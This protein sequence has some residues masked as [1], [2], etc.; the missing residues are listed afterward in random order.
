MSWLSLAAN[1]FEV[2]NI[3]QRNLKDNQELRTKTI[4]SMLGR[5]ALLS[6]DEFYIGREIKIAETILN[7]Y[8]EETRPPHQYV[9]SD[10][11]DLAIIASLGGGDY[12]DVLQS[13]AKAEI[14]DEREEKSLQLLAK[15]IIGTEMVPEKHYKKPGHIKKSG[16]WV[17]IVKEITPADSFDLAVTLEHP[18]SYLLEKFILP[19]GYL[20]ARSQKTEDWRTYFRHLLSWGSAD[21]EK[22]PNIV[23]ER[24]NNEPEEI[25]KAEPEDRKTWRGFDAVELLED[26]VIAYYYLGAKWE[27]PLFFQEEINVYSF[28]DGVEY[29]W[30]LV[31]ENISSETW[32]SISEI[33]NE[34]NCSYFVVYDSANAYA[35]EAAL[36]RACEYYNLKIVTK[37]I[38]EI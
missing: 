26:E 30:K 33:R 24:V 7:T 6:G 22:Q 28:L 16:E 2:K 38:T 12:S 34:K 13:I 3:L 32:K 1:R 21:F 18:E 23:Y 29:D 14:Y 5:Y 8:K 27:A 31:E 10:A 4:S 9:L 36:Q 37:D 35:P 20:L 11:F 17:K 19:L 15:R 25:V